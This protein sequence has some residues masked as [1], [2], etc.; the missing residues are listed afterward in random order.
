MAEGSSWPLC[1]LVD[2]ST[3]VVQGPNWL[4]WAGYFETTLSS[5]YNLQEFKIA[6][7]KRGNCHALS[8]QNYVILWQRLNIMTRN[9]TRVLE[10]RAKI[11]L[12]RISMDGSRRS[13]APIPLRSK[14]FLFF[15]FTPA[16]YLRN[17]WRTK[18]HQNEAHQRA[19]K[20]IQVPLSRSCLLFRLTLGKTLYLPFHILWNS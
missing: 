19:P 3:D 8:P 12:Q 17:V 11:E 9:L 2:L 20:A 1:S 16:K 7:V 13:R 4:E 18:T 5:G 14:E 6:S 15:L 10:M